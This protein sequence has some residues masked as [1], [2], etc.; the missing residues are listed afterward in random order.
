MDESIS[1]AFL[2]LLERLAPIERAV[3]LVRKVFEY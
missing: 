3:F 2:V 1:M